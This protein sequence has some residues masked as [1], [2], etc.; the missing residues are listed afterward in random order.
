MPNHQEN[1]KPRNSDIN[2]S[3]TFAKAAC[4]RKS[5]LLASSDTGYG[6]TF[7]LIGESYRDFEPSPILQ[8]I[9]VL[10]G[11]GHLG[12]LRVALPES[13]IGMLPAIA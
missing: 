13:C 11:A 12:F 5:T 4:M 8:A 7:R 10:A 2:R 9:P 6:T 1:V 3:I